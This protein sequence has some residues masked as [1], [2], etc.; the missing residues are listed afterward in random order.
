MVR[1]IATFRVLSDLPHRIKI[2]S[3]EPDMMPQLSDLK[4]TSLYVDDLGRSKSFYTSVLGLSILSED[5]RFCALDVAEKHV[6]LLFVRGASLG[7][8]NLPGGIIPP[9]DGS[10]PLHIAFAVTSEELPP[11]E[12]QLRTNRVEILSRVSWPKGGR[13]IYFRDPDG[14]LLE[15][16]T[17]GVWR[18]Y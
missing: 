2:G 6:L 7:E 3:I 11:W 4:E 18:T 1:L 15:L 16:L 17:P 8:T 13:S 14:H 12:S 5:E 10:G 9:H